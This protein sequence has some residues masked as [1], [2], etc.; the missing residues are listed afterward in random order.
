[1]RFE[2]IA[3]GDE[4]LDGR[5]TDGNSAALAR[6]LR[7]RGARLART[8]IVPDDV[9][10][11]AEALDEAA[12]RST[13]H[14]VVSGGLGPT[15][16]DLTRDAAALWSGAELVFDETSLAA[17]K[18]RFKRGGM[19]ITPNNHRQAWFPR[20]ARVLPNDVGT[21]PAFELAKSE[22]RAWFLPGVPSEYAFFIR[23]DI[24]PALTA[25]RFE[26]V[27]LK[28]FGL[29]ESKVASVV[30]ANPL[31]KDVVVGYRA[32]FP[33]IHVSLSAQL[34][35]DDDRLTRAR[36]VLLSALGRFVI[37]EGD[38][39]LVD[40]VGRELLSR[41]AT[42]TTAE[43]CTGGLVAEN[44]TRVPGSSAWFERGFVT[45]SNQAKI[46]LLG[47]SPA[48]LDA[49]GAV[50]RDTVI[51]MARGARTRA[52]AEYA[53]ALS[54]IAG[55]SGGTKDKPVGTVELAVDTP[56][57]T[58]YRPVH[59]RPYWGRQRIRIASATAGLALLLK[60][61]EGRVDDDP[62][63]IHVTDDHRAES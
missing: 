47:V 46:D 13:T 14:V 31:P 45:Y 20:G 39:E 36:E 21:A 6:S 11:I 7:E 9:A 8:T 62:G 60:L 33:E 57:G 32:H 5:V 25:G 40:R 19:S 23:R 12:R 22:L 61:L 29:T 38:E 30:V 10:A 15:E 48:T 52:S 35:A 1:M 53:I 56:E 34:D 3:I 24:V 58:W 55:P 49:F 17:I 63:A 59:M 44:L 2:T 37:A 27:R 43:S 54:G 26:T 4:L 51:E 41:G 42:V 18:A 16:D 28:F 50:S